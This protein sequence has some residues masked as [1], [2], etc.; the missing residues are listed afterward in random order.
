MPSAADSGAFTRG[1]VLEWYAEEGWG[2]LTSP[3]VDGTVFAHYSVILDQEGYRSLERGRP[4]AS[5][6]TRAARTAATTRP[7]R[8]PGH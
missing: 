4:F 1:E 8:Q 5:D 6:G 7:L 2:V 3:A